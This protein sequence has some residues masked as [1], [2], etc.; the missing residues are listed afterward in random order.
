MPEDVFGGRS[1][2][3]AHGQLRRAGFPVFAPTYAMRSVDDVEKDTSDARIVA[4]R[5]PLSIKH[6]VY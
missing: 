3:T 4:L 1:D 5:L 6:S 2:A